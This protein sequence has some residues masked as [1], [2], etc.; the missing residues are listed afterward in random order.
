MVCIVFKVCQ[1]KRQQIWTSQQHKRI[2]Q[3]GGTRKWVRGG[4]VVTVVTLQSYSI[5]SSEEEKNMK[6]KL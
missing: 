6:K 2:K 4:F 3:H 1:P 5:S